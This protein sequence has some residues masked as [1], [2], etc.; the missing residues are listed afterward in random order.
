MASGKTVILYQKSL[1]EIAA[2]PLLPENDVP[3]YVPTAEEKA[4]GRYAALTERLLEDGTPDWDSTIHMIPTFGMHHLIHSACWCE[5]KP[6]Y[7][8]DYYE[9]EASQ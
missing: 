1:A 3:T 4:M 2:L 8:P 5:P 6:M 7:D 9:H